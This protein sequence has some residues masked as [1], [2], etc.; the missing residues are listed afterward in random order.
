MMKSIYKTLKSIKTRLIRQTLTDKNDYS[1]RGNDFYLLHNTKN[2]ENEY[3]KKFLVSLMLQS[4]DINLQ[5][6]AFEILK[7]VFF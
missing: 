3:F 7:I 5:F 6:Y 4:N 1:E 2:A